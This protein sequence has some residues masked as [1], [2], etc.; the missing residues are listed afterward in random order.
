MQIDS[1]ILKQK[2]DEYY[3]KNISKNELGRWAK[4]GYYTLMKGEYLEIEKLEIYHFYFEKYREW[5]L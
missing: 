1:K 2:I 5:I 4:E 3:K